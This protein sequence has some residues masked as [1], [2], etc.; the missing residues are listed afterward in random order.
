MAEYTDREHYIP[1]R[2]SDLV[3]LLCAAQEL[4]AEER[5]QFRQLSQ[6][7]AAL[8]HYEYH[9]RLE[10]IKDEYA[11]FDPDA[12]TRP[13]KPLAA[14]AKDK[15]LDDLFN[16]FIW[17]MERANF[18][19][20]DH[21]TIQSAMSDVSA[22]GLNMEV[23][24][25]VFERLE[26]FSRGDITGPRT[27]KKWWRFWRPAETLK[28]PIYQRL[29][30]LLKLR[31]HK[32]LGPEVNTNGVF[33]KLFKDIPRMDLEMLLPGARMQMPRIARGKLGAS[34]ASALGWIGYKIYL[35]IKILAAALLTL[36]PFAF[37]GPL[38]LVLG[39]GYKQY[40]GY[41]FAKQ[42]YS[43]QLTQSL[44]FQNL[45]N[46]AGVLYHL[47][48]EAEEQE[49]REA[50]LAY[51]YLWRHANAD[52]WTSRNLDDY[53]E[54]DLERLASVKVDF[55]IGDAL[56]KL[57]KLHLVTANG[58]RYHA[59]PIAKALEILDECWDNIFPYHAPTVRA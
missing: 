46:N 41:Q 12:V 25:N 36:N 34:L 54:L 21:A 3:E 13:V 38:S 47:L 26:V 23:D 20:L 24:F 7:V 37:W 42:T 40:Y 45:D 28:V 29:V 5:Q 58:G 10:E 31:P 14:D 9:Q 43:L 51:Y 35:D 8:F 17:L 1:L 44:Y 6:L 11:P 53:I 4:S 15:K 2:K 55:E 16:R 27:L 57:E 52:G 32:R 19:R 50:L 33:L 39:Y 48:D 56:A 49:C 30:L 22:W 18:K 59:Q